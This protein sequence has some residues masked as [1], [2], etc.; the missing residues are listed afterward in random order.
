MNRFKITLPAVG[1]AFVCTAAPLWAQGLPGY[2]GNPANRPPVSPYLNLLRQGSPA[3]V[4]YYGLVRPEVNFQN[5]L[6]QAEQQIATNQQSIS[7]LAGGLPTT[8]HP[9]R[10]MTHWAHFLNTGIAPGIGSY[11]RSAPIAL[12]QTTQP[13]GAFAPSASAYRRF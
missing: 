7:S 5:A 12:P 1:L 4:N 11:R 2:G 13:T 10:Y 8:G 9:A 3:A 6:Y